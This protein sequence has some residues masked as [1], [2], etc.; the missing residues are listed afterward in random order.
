MT[1]GLYAV[2]G[3]QESERPGG[4]AVYTPN[5]A[6][7]R[8]AFFTPQATAP[9]SAPRFSNDLVIFAQGASA[10]GVGG[11]SA[12][13]GELR[14]PRKVVV[15]PEAPAV[16]ELERLERKYRAPRWSGHQ[17]V[18]RVTPKTVPK[19]REKAREATQDE[20]TAEELVEVL[21]PLPAVQARAEALRERIA[22]RRRDEESILA[23]LLEI[24]RMKP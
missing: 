2:V 24:A 15:P 19:L 20:R 14:P 4:T 7:E 23:M 21:A 9:V 18:E 5:S 1:G 16:R 10:A 22:R 6:L 8:L 11:A 13:G 17:R 12:K 3:L